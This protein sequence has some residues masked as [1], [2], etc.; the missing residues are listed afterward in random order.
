MKENR[1]ES[2]SDLC[3]QRLTAYLDLNLDKCYVIPLN[4]STVMPPRDL[5]EL[6]VNVRVTTGSFDEWPHTDL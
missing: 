4:T 5:M 2:S 6:L 3:F 1:E